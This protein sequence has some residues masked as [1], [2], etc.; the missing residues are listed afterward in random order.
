MLNLILY[1]GFYLL[2]VYVFRLEP[3]GTVSGLILSIAITILNRLE[4]LE[5]KIRN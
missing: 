5:K 1:V 3:E 2:F 4:K